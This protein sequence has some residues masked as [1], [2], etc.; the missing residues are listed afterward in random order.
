MQLPE[1][2][3]VIYDLLLFTGMAIIYIS[4]AIILTFIPR[5]YR[6]K[7]VKGEIALITGGAGG[8]GRLI[9]IK[10]ANLGAHVVIWDINKTGL[11][12]TVQEIRRSGGKCWGYY[13]D[14]TSREEVYR[15]AKIV[16][17]EVGSVTLLINNAGYVYGKTL[18]E[19]PDDEIIRTYKVNILS[20]YW[21]TKAFMKDMMKNNHGHIVTVASVAGLLGTY[22]CTDYSAT[23]FAAIGYHESLFTELKTHEYDGIHTTL[24]CPYFINTG[25]FHG[26]KPRLMPMLEPEYVAQEVVS[27]ILLNQVIVVLPG[28]VR[29]LL[30][31]KCLLPA[32][33]CWALMYHIIQGPQ[34]MMMFQGRGEIQALKNNNN[35]AIMPEETVH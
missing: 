18:W 2:A 12:D 29:Y 25:M 3:I 6:V 21:I 10:L 15:M 17:I 11:K 19:L 5:R 7:S 35:V 14:I 20:H 32:K 4:E 8:I 26:V 28:S 24:V 31:L 33:L 9:A 16:Q 23:K 1:W 27:G 13:C 30:P 34:S 22:N